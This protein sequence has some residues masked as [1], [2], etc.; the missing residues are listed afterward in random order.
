MICA[1]WV[2]FKRN[3]GEDSY[4]SGC[5]PVLCLQ[6]TMVSAKRQGE[7]LMNTQ[8]IRKRGFTLIELLVVI[9]IIAIL[10]AILFPVFGRA[11]ENA[12]RLSCQSNLKQ[13]GLGVLQY[14]QDYD[15]MYPIQGQGVNWGAFDAGITGGWAFIIQPYV[16][17]TQI[18]QCPSETNSG[19]STASATNYQYTDYAY[20]S[21]LGG[22]SPNQAGGETSSSSTGPLLPRSASVLT[23]SSN[24]IMLL[25]SPAVSNLNGH[26]AQGSSG[27]ATGVGV[28]ASLPPYGASFRHLEGSNF[29]FADGHVKWFKTDPS[30]GTGN[31]AGRSNAIFGRQTAPTGSNAT[32]ALSGS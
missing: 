6:K 20:N 32:Y 4:C 2:I 19:D 29:L 1:I 5:L 18:L 3:K 30:V 22:M 14:V 26:W 9:A 16:K 23:F 12:R 28:P 21:V 13:I 8:V 25:E 7:F 24:T 10:A 17:S 15:E 27:G 31:T 11:R